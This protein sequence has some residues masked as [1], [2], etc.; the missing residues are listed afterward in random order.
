MQRLEVSGAVRLIYRSLGVKRLRYSCNVK[1]YTY[2][3]HWMN[4]V[5]SFRPRP[6]YSSQR[7]LATHSGPPIVVTDFR[8]AEQSLASHRI[9]TSNSPVADRGSTVVKVLCY[10]LE[11]RWFHPSWCQWIFH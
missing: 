1:L 9:Q 2:P 7:A 3:R 10:K 4:S 8:R 6:L 5:V 11:G